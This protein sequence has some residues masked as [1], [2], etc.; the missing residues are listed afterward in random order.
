MKQIN[1]ITFI[2]LTGLYF[3]LNA[4]YYYDAFSGNRTVHLA[5][6]MSVIIIIS[7]ITNILVLK[8][9]PEWVGFKYVSITGFLTLCTVMMF[10]GKNDYVYVII[11]LFVSVYILYYDL[12]F[13]ISIGIYFNVLNISSLLYHTRNGTTASG[14]PINKSSLIIQ[15]L[16]I[17]VFF[18]LLSI[19]TYMSNKINTTKTKLLVEERNKSEKMLNDV[20]KTAKLVKDNAERGNKY[21]EELDVATNNTLNIFQDIANGNIQNSESVEKQT[22][23]TANITSMIEKVVDNANKAVDATKTSIDG[24]N[25]GKRVVLS[26]KEMSNRISKSNE[27]V[28]LVMRDFVDNAKKVKQIT[29]GIIDISD[30]TNL[31]SLNASIESARAGEVGKGFAVVAGEIR[32]L[33]EQTSVLTNN[34]EKIVHLLENN[35]SKAQNVIEGVVDAIQEENST[36]EETLE[37]FMQIEQDMEGLDKDMKLILSSTNDVVNSNNTIIEHISQLSASSEHVTACTE[38]ALI[39]NEENRNKSHDTKEVMNQ[40]LSAAEDLEKYM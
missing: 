22:E 28:I 18:T 33:A 35:A 38:E 11:F 10:M 16:G 19:T 8:K 2:S 9:N 15:V 34:I 6:I 23:L 31:L 40:L 25:K 39:V 24:I 12:K 4:G 21:I 37:Y 36:I 14:A 29:E 1:K 20:L 5:A 30:Q 17:F 32:N 3:L 7:T 26:L 13:I 27:E